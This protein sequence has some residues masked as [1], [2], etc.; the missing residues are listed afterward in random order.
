MDKIQLIKRLEGIQDLMEVVPHLN[1]PVNLLPFPQHLKKLNHVFVIAIIQDH[2]NQ[3][4]VPDDIVNF[5][6]VFV[7]SQFEKCQDFLLGG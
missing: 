6:D 5:D 7:P 2:V 4:F 3:L 1:L